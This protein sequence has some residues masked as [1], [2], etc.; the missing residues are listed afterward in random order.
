MYNVQCQIA[1]SQNRY[2]LKI[3]SL[4]SPAVVNECLGPKQ[5]FFSHNWHKTLQVDDRFGRV[6]TTIL[7]S[8]SST[9]QQFQE[10]F[11]S[12]F[13]LLLISIRPHVFLKNIDHATATEFKNNWII[14]L[15]RI[16][17]Y[18]QQGFHNSIR[19]SHMVTQ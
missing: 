3:S 5:Q 4:N 9:K 13:E 7:A 16:Q 2:R 19:N 10:T 11:P 6:L 12:I 14:P 15:K 8:Q 18:T 17:E 1:K